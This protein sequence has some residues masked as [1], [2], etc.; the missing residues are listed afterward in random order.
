MK[1]FVV[2]IF[3]FILPFICTAC[4]S[5]T[6]NKNQSSFI[7]ISDN[8]KDKVCKQALASANINSVSNYINTTT[9]HNNIFEAQ[10][11]SQ[12]TGYVYDCIFDSQD[13]FS[14]KGEGWD[15]IIPQGV[16]SNGYEENCATFT[17]NDPAFGTSKTYNVCE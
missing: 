12:E 5:D 9:S 1:K 15:N 6:N 13:I 4:T 14:I 8:L 7:P 16:I 10:Y 17:L 3:L 2:W 11:K